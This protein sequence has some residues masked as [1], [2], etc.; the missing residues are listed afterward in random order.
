MPT[1]LNV[2]IRLER[3]LIIFFCLALAGLMV[4]QV[5]L[6]YVFV[7]PFLGFEEVTVLLGLWIYFLGPRPHHSHHASTS[8]AESYSSSF[9]ARSRTRRLRSSSSR[10]AP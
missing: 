8:Q 4:V 10:C 3:A 2:L 7:A 6:R 5:I 9:K 1:M